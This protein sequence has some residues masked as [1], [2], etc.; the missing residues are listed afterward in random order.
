MT[1][2]PD[3]PSGMDPATKAFFDRER[4]QQIA[5]NVSDLLV[6]EKTKHWAYELHK[7]AAPG[8]K[9]HALKSRNSVRQAAN[10][11]IKALNH[12]EAEIAATLRGD[13]S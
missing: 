1:D 6:F 7:L 13:P 5:P 12:F 2:E 10:N 4:R 3:L 9:F 11:L 8:G